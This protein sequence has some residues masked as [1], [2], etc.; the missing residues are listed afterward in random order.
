[1]RKNET[2][3]MNNTAT[4]KAGPNSGKTQEQLIQ[5]FFGSLDRW[6]VKQEGNNFGQ[7]QILAITEHM[8]RTGD[9]LWHSQ[10]V[11][12]GW[13]EC[14]CADCEREAAALKAKTAL[15]TRF[16]ND[17]LKIEVEVANMATGGYSVTVFDFID[18]KSTHI[19]AHRSLPRA[20]Q[21]AEALAGTDAV[22]YPLGVAR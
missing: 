12:M 18:G 9:C 15:I 2:K 11:V 19:E 13:K 6:P 1:M 7:D 3:H 21:S 22:E 8:A 4:K 17:G 20:I 10:T 5:K 16:V 14:H